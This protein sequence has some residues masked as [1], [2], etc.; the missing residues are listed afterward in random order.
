LEEKR[1]EEK[2]KDLKIFEENKNLDDF[3]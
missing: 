1:K 2:L 3:K